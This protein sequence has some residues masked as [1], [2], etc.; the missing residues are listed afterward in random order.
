MRST[1]PQVLIID[2]DELFH[3]AVKQVLKNHYESHSAFHTDEAKIILKKKRIDLILLDVQMRTPTEGIEFISVLREQYPEI[4]IVMSSGN[5]DVDTVKTAILKGAHDYVAKDFE[6][7]DLIHTL[8]KNLNHAKLKERNQQ[9]SFELRHTHST[10]HRFIGQ[11]KTILKIKLDIEK[12]KKTKPNVIIHGKTGSGKEIIARQLR[13]TH[14]DGSLAPFIAVDSSTIQSSMA[15]SLLFGH[16]KG[17]FTDAKDLRRGIFEEANGGIVYFDEIANMPL[18]IQSKLLR[19]LEEKEISRIGS[20]KTIPLEFQVICATNQNLF[21]M[22]SKGLFKEDLLQRL[23]VIPIQ[24]PSLSERPEDIPLLLNHFLK[25]YDHSGKKFN[26][27]EETLEI[28]KLY[29]WPGN[30]RELSN[31]INYLTTMCES[32]E[33]QPADLPP[34][35]RNITPSPNRDKTGKN[36]Y[37]EVENFEKNFLY[38]A[39][40]KSKGN[41]SK[42]ALEVGMDRSHLYTKL[43]AYQIHFPR[44]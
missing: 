27:T 7:D 37:E 31:L 44:T 35:I 38:H 21:E 25:K 13:W 11:S 30:V 2:D 14:E 39:Y 20:N 6:P 29:S 34:H 4:L 40:E 15:E 5:T 28:L 1:K 41:I 16:E 9:V 36:F 23:N 33:V 17:A 8:S 19:V 3:M 24:V 42:M 22:V 26:V 43:K 18:E 32:T 10:K 12:I